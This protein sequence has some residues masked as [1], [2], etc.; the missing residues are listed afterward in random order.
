[1]TGDW[2]TAAEAADPA[3][4]VRHLLGTVRFAGGLSTLAAEPE[5]ALLEVG[6]GHALTTL[7]LQAGG[8]GPDRLAFASLR[9]AYDATPDDAFLHGALGRLWLAG[10]AVDWAGF[11]AGQRR[12]KMM[13]PAYPFQRQRYWI[14][15]SAPA[16]APAAGLAAADATAETVAPPAYSRPGLRTG[17][18]PPRDADE[19]AV[20]AVWEA[21]LGLQP[22]GIHD[23]FFELGGHSL[24]APRL[25][26]EVRR[27]LG[28][29]VPLADLLAAPTVADLAAEVARRRRGDGLERPA[30]P[31]LDLRAEAVLAPEIRVSSPASS[32]ALAPAGAGV[33]L[34]G[35]TGFLGVYLL[36]D[37]LAAGHTVHCLVRAA[38]PEEG[39][40]RLLR[41]LAA[42]RLDVRGGEERLVAVAGDLAAPRWGLSEADFVA[43]AGRVGAVYHCGA[44][45]NFTYPYRALAPANVRGTEE[46]LR[47]AATGA[48]KP[49]HF[50]S[51]LAVF[52][53]GS[54]TSAGVGLEDADLA[55][56]ELAGGYAQTK[57]VAE[58]LVR[59][60]R[61]RGVPAAVYRPA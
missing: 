23:S 18:V 60:A 36:R 48:A 49:C 51:S 58:S 26:L 22:V 12:L 30:S 19:A 55:I 3:Y 24:L 42:H 25:L 29:E 52:V 1:M 38:S 46:A 20:A 53:P 17:Y 40:G 4:W 16:A 50:V 14:E 34:T 7:A 39:R 28:V 10:V 45:V 56:P 57:W 6:P 11:H 41:N 15:P 61:E 8:A 37:L 31:A 5:L 13:L 54:F 2:I 9:P 47:L 44:W 21:V 33:L 59:Q 32:P 35:A 43:L 27:S